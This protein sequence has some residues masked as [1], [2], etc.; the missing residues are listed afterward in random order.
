MNN[1]TLI[2]SGV[3]ILSLL[4]LL[5]QVPTVLAQDTE[6]Q[7]YRVIK[8][9]NAAEL[10][11]YPPVMKIQSNND[12]GSLFNY[13]SGNNST[14]EKISMTSPVYMGDSKGRNVMEFVLPEDFNPKNTPDALS[15]GVKVFESE[16]GYFLAL[17]SI[18][19]PEVFFLSLKFET[20]ICPLRTLVKISLILLFEF[21]KEIVRVTSVVPNSYWPPESTK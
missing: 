18:S 4:I 12:F 5:F 3:R 8:E 13:I 19:A 16:P 20:A 10:R 15:K 7:T 11:Y 17:E 1:F 14:R 6:T 9:Y 2:P 21:F